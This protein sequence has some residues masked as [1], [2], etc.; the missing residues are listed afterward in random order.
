M[1]LYHTHRSHR[2][3]WLRASVLGANDGIIS[4][5]SMLI[6]FIAAKT[7]QEE[8]MLAGFA[9]LV[10]GAM[11]MA[12][13]E[14]VSVR[15]Q[16]DIEEADLALEKISLRDNREYEVK[17]LAE[18]YQQR[19]IE[20]ELSYQ[21]AKQ[22]MAHDA[23][24]AHARDEIG[25]QEISKARPVQAALSSALTFSLGA[26]LPLLAVLLAPVQYQFYAVLL[27]SL[28]CLALLG[29]IAARVGGASKLKGASRVVFWGVMAMALTAAVGRI[30][31][32]L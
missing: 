23:L 25:I 16:A 5:A 19:G 1:S 13:G 31:G 6:G 29:A 18:I 2:A 22:L 3:G 7:S 12:A 24:A 27:S 14:Y 11:S 8:L 30:Y 17:E 32:A 26:V 4:T 21:V 20:I 15:S 9:S 28:L 10:A